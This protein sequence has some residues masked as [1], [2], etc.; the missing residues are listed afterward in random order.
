MT[1]V[2]EYLA[3]TDPAAMLAWLRDED[4]TPARQGRPLLT[5]RKMRL[6]VCVC[7]RLAGVPT[8]DW[9]E[10]GGGWLKDDWSLTLDW[11]EGWAESDNPPPTPSKAAR[12]ALLRATVNPFAPPLPDECRTELIRGLAE[13]AYTERQDDG[14]L[15]PQ[16]LA[17]LSDALEEAGLETAACLECKGKG[18]LRQEHGYYVGD[19]RTCKKTGRIPNPLLA[20]LREQTPR[21]RGFWVIDMLTGME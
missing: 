19:C 4:E 17:V 3:C 18:V 21:W 7:C 10:D 12:A 5:A 1:K 8:E 6:W 11:A 13:G 14:T 16:R 15:D 2:Q 9:D 20:A